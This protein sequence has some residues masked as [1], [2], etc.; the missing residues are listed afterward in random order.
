M[1]PY[2]FPYIGYWQL[3]NA[4]D[5]FIIY[6][7]VSYIKSGWIN[8]NQI[9]MTGKNKM[10]NLQTRYASSN[11]LI[12]EVEVFR[13]QINSTKLLKTLEQYYKKAPQYMNTLSLIK[14][15]IS[16]EEK[17]LALYLI[18]SIRKICEF[19]TI[20]TEIIVSSAIK[21]NNNL[22]GQDKIMKIC[23]ILGADEYINLIGGQSLY[24][25][26]I[27][28][29]NDL[30]L[31]FIKPGDIRYKQFGNHFIPNL[32]IIDVMMF[33]SVGAIKNMLT[34]YELI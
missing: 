29:E 1:Q 30:T 14:N 6:D 32:S 21:K 8:R 4:V 18:Y 31:Q 7:D 23:K 17:N 12:N 9:L 25:K 3:I 15:I 2:F 13:N 34:D 24:S 20:E 10:I 26:E 16:Q 11:R 28:A 22:R 5:K 19:L 33:N 27:F